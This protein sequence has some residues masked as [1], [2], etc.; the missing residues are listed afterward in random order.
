[1]KKWYRLA[2]AVLVYALPAHPLLAAAV[3]QEPPPP[4]SSREL[5]TFGVG[6]FSVPLDIIVRDKKGHAVRDLK[7]SD[8]E[9]FEDGVKQKI[10]SFEVYGRPPADAVRVEAKGAPAAPAP[11]APAAPLATVPEAP[12]PDVRPQVIAFVFDR[13]SADARDTAHKA[14]LTYLDKGHV[15]GDL[16]G[17]FT[18]DLALRTLQ[19]FTNETFLIRTALDKAASQGN[20]AFA[21]NAAARR[22]LIETVASSERANDSVGAGAG[23]G[24]N[25]GSIGGAA[26]SAA[27]TQA[28]ASV[29]AGML[30]NFEALERDQQGYA[31]TNGLLAVVSGLKSLPGRK[32]VVFFSEGLAVPSNVEAQFKNVIANAN[33]AN[34][35]VYAMDAAGLRTHSLNEETR[36][37]MMQANARRQRVLES[38]RDD[39]TTGSMSKQLER[40]ED[41]LRLNP[42]SGLG[43]LANDTGGFLI[44]NTNDAAAA[45]R[46][47]EED[48]RFYYL[49]GYSPT[50][51]NYDGKFRTI[52]VKVNRP[53]VQV[54]TRQGYLAVRS[55]ESAPLKSFE[56]PALVQLDK[57]PRPTQF[58][59]QAT[60][61]SFPNPKRPGLSPVLV[62]VPGNTITYVLDPA[63]KTGKKMYRADFSVVARVRN[64]AGQEVDR[65]SQHYVLSAPEA[66]LAAARGGDLLFYRE[67]DLGA[68]RHTVEAVGYDALS[69]K[70]SVGTTT[71]DV[72]K[73]EAGRPSLSSI[74]L[75]GHAEKVAPSEQQADNP[76]YYGETVLYP[77][78]GEPFRKAT[79]PALGFFFTI[80]GMEG[81]TRKAII[82][83]FRG[84]LAAGQVTADLPAPDANGRI[85]YA[86][87]LP[88]QSF[89]P[90]SYRIKVTA[91]AKTGFDTRQ[92]SFTLTE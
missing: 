86:G 3:A 33:R 22:N 28:V 19:P 8:F 57:K 38:G 66:N 51:E 79:T 75:V 26:G 72:P 52:S 13:L 87:A 65:L 76:L 40:N 36:K 73:I 48:M 61:L 90:G 56:A 71:V 80:Y 2:A 78:M 67:A 84:D 10:E 9:V 54:Q 5:P 49:A 32:T 14:A 59:I 25:A 24:S 68:G 27:M 53:G 6:S 34:V 74:V 39:G 60:A 47:I 30:R 29:Q 91:Q 4:P 89:A 85:Q 92:T 46:R 1:M 16:V 18:I 69:Q 58:P 21:D 41:L 15:D 45:F 88:L 17:V 23:Q 70:A 83:V 77:N 31:S 62:R 64:D 50:N 11:T 35:S 42:E 82:E 55:A 44:I 81:D 43:Q 63:D 20:T 37:E 12:E 7:A